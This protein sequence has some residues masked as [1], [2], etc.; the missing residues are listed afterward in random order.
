MFGFQNVN[1][2]F[3]KSQPPFGVPQG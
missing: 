1:V 2:L 3:E